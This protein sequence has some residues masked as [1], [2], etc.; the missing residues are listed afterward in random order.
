MRYTIECK[1]QPLDTTACPFVCPCAAY[2][3]ERL[4]KYYSFFG[5]KPVRRVTGGELSDLPHML[6]WGG[7]GMRMDADVEAM[8]AK[9]TPALRRAAFVR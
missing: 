6:V 8:L 7:A 3:H 9:W 1:E 4:V 2:T 5:F